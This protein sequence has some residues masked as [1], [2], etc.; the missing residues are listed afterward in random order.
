[1]VCAPSNTAVDQVIE[2]VTQHGLLM[3]RKPRLIRM[4]VLSDNSSSAVVASS[5]EE[6]VRREMSALLKVK[7]EHLR[8]SV[9]ALHRKIAKL[10]HRLPK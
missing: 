5:L 3:G 8:M 6:Q 7:Q 9:P 4:G 1:M 2:R 10:E